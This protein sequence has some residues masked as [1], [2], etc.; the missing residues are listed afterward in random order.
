M[1][2]YVM[3]MRTFAL[4]FVILSLAETSDANASQFTMTVVYDNTVHLQGTK[5]AWG[6]AC[7]IE[8]AEKTILFDTGGSGQILLQNIDSLNIDLDDL[9]VT[10]ISH[11]HPDHTGGLDSVLAKKPDESIYFGKSYP[12]SFTQH[13]ISKGAVAIRVD[14]PVEICGRVYST[15]EIQGVANEQS[16]IFD[17]DSGLVIITGCAHT[18]IINILNKAREI[19]DKDIYLVFGGFHLL[20]QSD[21]AVNQIIGQFKSLGVKKCGATHCTGDRAIAL[22]KEAYGEDYIPMGVG[23]VIQ[24]STNNPVSTIEEGN[25]QPNV[26]GRFL[27][28]QNFPNPFNPITEISY[29]LPRTGHVKLIVCDANGR[30]AAVLA[31][32]TKTSGTHTVRFNASRLSSGVYIYRIETAQEVLSKKLMLLK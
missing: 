11:N 24:V 9:D 31:D 20:D 6:F 1:R 29:S 10:V 21:A 19:L 4:L 5:P 30:Q 8:G 16:L 18:G 26:P 7:Y 25:S 27:L 13:A 17:T 23:Q 28:E 22:F 3:T 15:G 32:E 12:E 2:K 14:N